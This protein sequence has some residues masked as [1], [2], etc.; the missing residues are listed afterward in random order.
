M[1]LLRPK[2][3]CSYKLHYESITAHNSP[4]VNPPATL[5][6]AAFYTPSNKAVHTADPDSKWIGVGFELEVG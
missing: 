2:A 4:I 3:F 5:H 6:D 1:Y